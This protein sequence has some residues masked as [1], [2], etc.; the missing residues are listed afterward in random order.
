NGVS[1]MDASTLGKIDIQGEDAAT[2]LNLV[3]TNSWSKLAVGRCRYGLMLDENGMAMDDGVTTRLAEHHYLMTTTTGGAARVLA[4]LERW[5]QTEWPHLKV[6]LT[7]VTDHWA[8]TAIVGPKS[9]DLLRTLCTDVD[10]DDEA[11]PFMSYREGTVAGVR[12]RI[13]RIS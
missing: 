5:L 9:R 7:T 10:F 4:W 6:F 12:A 8:T 11:F 1:I 13:M 2:F 3:Y